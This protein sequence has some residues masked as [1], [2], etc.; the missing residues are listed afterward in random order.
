MSERRTMS[1]LTTVVSLATVLLVAGCAHDEQAKQKLC[2]QEEPD[3][4]LLREPTLAKFISEC[5]LEYYPDATGLITLHYH[6]QRRDGTLPVS[7]PRAF[8]VSEAGGLHGR[9][10]Y[11]CLPIPTIA[12]AS[13][14]VSS[15]QVVCRYGGSGADRLSLVYD[16]ADAAMH[17]PKSW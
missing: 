4:T 11:L 14:K 16:P 1:R 15:I 12:D 10:W 7:A 9:L 2:A 5:G 17:D 3:Q 13:G 8:S 6:P